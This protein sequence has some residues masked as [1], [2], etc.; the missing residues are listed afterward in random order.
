MEGD[1]LGLGMAFK[2]KLR[3]YDFGIKGLESI[4]F[5]PLLKSHVSRPDQLK[6]LN[7]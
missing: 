5:Q 2:R 3:D 6:A 1:G 4:A 7:V